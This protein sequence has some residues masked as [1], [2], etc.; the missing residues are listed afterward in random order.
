M[1]MDVTEQPQFHKQADP[2][3]GE[4]LR[5]SA[6]SVTVESVV[7][8]SPDEG[9]YV[10][11]MAGWASSGLLTVCR[12][13]EERCER[14][15]RNILTNRSGFVDVLYAGALEH[16]VLGHLGLLLEDVC[17]DRLV[18]DPIGLVDACRTGIWLSELVIQTGAIGAI[19][20]EVCVRLVGETPL[21]IAATGARF[22]LDTA[23]GSIGREPAFPTSYLAPEQVLGR[24]TTEK[25]DVY[26]IAASVIWLVNGR[27]V[28]AGETFGEHVS[29]IAAGAIRSDIELPLDEFL[30]PN[31]RRRPGPEVLHRTLE[32]LCASNG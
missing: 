6:G 25:S 12:T 19:R 5:T 31:P 17:P 11:R 23:G 4:T 16:P 9:Q 22:L 24:S 7:R 32:G 14:G 1:T 28:T 3:V 2:L 27:H 26:A 10:A 8:G 18:T 29:L 30:Q 21:A 15:L 20:P 13:S